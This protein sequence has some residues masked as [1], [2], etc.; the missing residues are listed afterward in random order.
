MAKSK[1]L[2]FKREIFLL[3]LVG[4]LIH[5]IQKKEF[6]LTSKLLYN[7]PKLCLVMCYDNKTERMSARY[8]SIRC[9]Y[10][11]ISANH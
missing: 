6:L 4:S 2:S 1:V 11:F 9:S 3:D 8:I 7:V 5:I 10:L